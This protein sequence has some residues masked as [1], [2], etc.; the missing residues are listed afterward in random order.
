MKKY[1]PMG[2]FSFQLLCILISK[3]LLNILMEVWSL[4]KLIKMGLV[5]S[6]PFVRNCYT[7]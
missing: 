4:E 3:T 2:A 5:L 1:E 7:I 6:I